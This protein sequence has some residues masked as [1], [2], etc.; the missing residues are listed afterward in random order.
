MAFG[1]KNAAQTFQRYIDSALGNIRC[2]FVYIDDILIASETAE[3][4]QRDIESVLARL[5]KFNL[6]LNT[7][8]CLLGQTELEFL[9]HTVNQFGFKPTAEKTEAIS[10]F[11][12]PKN[13]TELRRFLGMLN[14]YRGTIKHAAHVQEPLLKFLAGAKKKDLRPIEWDP[15]TIA[16]FEQCRKSILDATELAFPSEH[17][18]IRLVTDASDAAMGAA[19]EQKSAEDWR[20]V[21]FYSKKFNPA[22]CKYSTYDRELT[23]I[24]CAIRKFYYYLEGRKFDVIT[25]HKP[26]M[27]ALSQSHDK[28]P[29]IRVRQVSYISQFDCKIV[30]RPGS[31]NAVADA[32]SRIE[33]FRVPSMF[34]WEY[35]WNALDDDCQRVRR[36]VDAFRLPTLFD[37]KD[38]ANKQDEDLELP[39]IL[40][41]PEN[42]LKLKQLLFNDDETPF[43]CDITGN[44]IRPYIPE[45]LREELFRL[46][47]NTSHP[48]GKVTDRLLRQQYVW[49][50]M[51][52]DVAKWCKNCVACQAA[53]VSRHNK[54][55][56]SQF[57]APD[58]RFEHVHIDIVGPLPVYEGYQYLLTMVDRYS[59]WPEAIPMR[60]ITARTVAHAFYTNWAA[61]YG[62]PK[63][64]TTDQGAQFEARLFRELLDFIGCDR[65]RTTAYHPAANGL[66]ERWHRDLKAALMCYGDDPEWPRILPT[67]L[68][69]LRTRIREKT[70]AS[71]ADYVFGTSLRIPGAFYAENAHEPDD[72]AFLVE[73][74]DYVNKVR[75]VPVEH[76]ITPKGFVFKSIRDCSHVFLQRGAKKTPLHRPYTGPHRVIDRSFDGKDYVIDI[77]GTHKTVNIE[78]LKPAFVLEDELE[79]TETLTPPEPDLDYTAIDADAEVE[80]LGRITPTRDH[81]PEIQDENPT[82]SNNCNQPE[83]EHSD[84][85]GRSEI[86]DREGP[87]VQPAREP[88]V[89]SPRRSPRRERAKPQSP[90]TAKRQK[91][92][93]NILR[94]NTNRQIDC[95]HQYMLGISRPNTNILTRSISDI[96]RSE[97]PPLRP[98]GNYM[99]SSRPWS[100]GNLHSHAEN[101][102]PKLSWRT[103]ACSNSATSLP[104]HTNGKL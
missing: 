78:R 63:R 103:Y 95:L 70:G 67:V 42:P 10:N 54:P 96:N 87:E 76:N 58:S 81:S 3:Q 21:A 56:P 24:Y 35:G 30:Y 14:F 100:A 16:A 17:A 85:D 52:R 7:D 8:K 83:Y 94:K 71:P 68:L 27:Y 31:E 79:G 23:A 90:A 28:A 13:V 57:I 98:S 93:P 36:Q 72:G 15:V 34:D 9:G 62:A 22:Q 61:R 86:S 4:H 99:G 45:S 1:F 50:N 43:Y 6:R 51:S 104:R 47:H 80:R 37:A 75:P 33:S 92:R 26:L 59:R 48:S 65:I 25:D 19:L 97:S 60:N 101:K 102:G 38:L 2:A 49:P 73:L 40:R 18:E 77:D 29:A 82:D 20:P 39:H 44:T 84:A 55:V 88:V 11:P 5:D 66:V 32:L 41:D 89:Q 12:R 91:H 64:V 46:F 74:K 69:G 53:K